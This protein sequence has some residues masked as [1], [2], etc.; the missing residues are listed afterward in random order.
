[1]TKLIDLLKILVIIAYLLCG[2][3]ELRTGFYK[4]QEVR[5]KH[6]IVLK[7]VTEPLYFPVDTLKVGDRVYIQR[8]KRENKA[9][10]W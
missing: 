6:T 1:M 5:G 10:I 9:N 8:V 2:C 7:G 3:S 4:V